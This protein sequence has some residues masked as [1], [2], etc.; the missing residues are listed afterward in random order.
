M[1]SIDIPSIEEIYMVS[2]VTQKGWEP[3]YNFELWKKEG[4]ITTT[5]KHHPCGCCSKDVET[6]WFS[7]EEAFEEEKYGP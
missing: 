5:K 4:H 3:D 7:L 2:Y 6:E 1:S